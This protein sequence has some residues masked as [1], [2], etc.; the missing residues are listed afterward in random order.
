MQSETVKTDTALGS[1]PK[2]RRTWTDVPDPVTGS[3]SAQVTIVLDALV[4]LLHV[5]RFHRRGIIVDPFTGGLFHAFLP[6]DG[7]RRSVARGPRI[8]KRKPVSKP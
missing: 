8:V 5:C 2:R 3:S 6:S 7:F 4:F 1:R